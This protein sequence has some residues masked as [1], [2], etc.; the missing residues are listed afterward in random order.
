MAQSNNNGSQNS[1]KLVTAFRWCLFVS[2]MSG[3]VISIS[4][5]EQQRQIAKAKQHV[6]QH[7]DSLVL[8]SLS[9]TTEYLLAK[10]MTELSAQRER[11]IRSYYES[12]EK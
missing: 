2:I 10:K 8:D 1:S 4:K 6:Q 9:K 11:E 7:R 12:I 3:V 5:S